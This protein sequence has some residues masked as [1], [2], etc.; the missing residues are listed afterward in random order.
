MK[1]FIFTT[2]KQ[3]HR[4]AMG[5]A[6][7][8]ILGFGVTM[9]IVTFKENTRLRGLEKDVI[10]AHEESSK[11]YR[12]NLFFIQEACAGRRVTFEKQRCSKMGLGNSH[13]E[14]LFPN[15]YQ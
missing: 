14:P 6:A 9:A 12:K 2:A 7:L 4:V 13:A 11:Q 8:L 10:E 5:V 15:P 1:A 3:W